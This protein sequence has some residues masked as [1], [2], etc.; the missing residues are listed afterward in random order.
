MTTQPLP[1]NLHLSQCYRLLDTERDTLQEGDEVEDP[2]SSDWFSIETS[3]IGKH[4]R[5]GQLHRRPFTPPAP[6]Q[7]QEFWRLLEVGKDTLQEGDEICN[8]LWRPVYDD[9]IGRSPSKHYNYRRR[10][11]VPVASPAPAPVAHAPKAEPVTEC[12]PY[13]VSVDGKPAPI[14][15]HDTIEDARAEAERLA[16][17]H[18]P[19]L[20]RL[21]R[22][23][24]TVEVEIITKWDFRKK[25]PK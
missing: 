18:H 8:S 2:F 7:V 14:K 5:P 23:V 11:T 24:G 17:N 4:P 1:Q 9:H 25:Q 21:L 13:L 19:A 3:D 12:G 15:E 22:Q 20:V 16:T 6:V 10:V